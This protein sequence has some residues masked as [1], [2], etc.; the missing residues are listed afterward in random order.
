VSTSPAIPTLAAEHALGLVR[1]G[2]VVGLGSG[3][4]ATAF[5]QLL[6]ERV[7]QGLHVRCIPTS[8]ATAALATRVGLPL[9]TLDECDAIDLTVDGADEVDPRLDLIK[10][11]G[12]ALVREKVVAAASRRLVILVGGDKLV[13]RLGDRGTLPVEV[14]PFALGFCRRRLEALGL[15]PRPRADGDKLYVTDNGNHI[16]DCATPA[17][18]D[19]AALAARLDALPGVVGHGL[20]LGMA[21]AVVVQRGEAVEVLGVAVRG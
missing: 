1:E 21:H 16:L 9:S 12:G 4:A 10:G 6:G 13:P 2:D 19:P 15:P 20:F 5:V 3:R 14:V 17:L 7:R 11:L 8:S 18:D